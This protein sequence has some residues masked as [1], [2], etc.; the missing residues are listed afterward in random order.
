[1]TSRDVA[2][3]VMV[4]VICCSARAL[5]GAAPGTPD[6]ITIRMY[7]YARLKPGILVRTQ[8]EVGRIYRG[9]GVDIHWAE[10]IRET[11]LATTAALDV[12]PAELLVMLLNDRMA[13]RAGM[14]TDVVG[15]AATSEDGPGRIAYVMVDRARRAAGQSA[16]G[17]DDVLALVVAHELGH[18]L[19]P[20]GHL[21]LPH[22]SHSASGVM[23]ANLDLKDLPYDRGRFEFTPMQGETIRQ[24]VRTP[25]LAAEK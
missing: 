12:D 11:D 6:G 4:A 10:T 14:P 5:F 25:T 24:R 17:L 23:R 20:H 1:M 19:L 8:T 3:T 18:L 21:L 22:G 13:S 7:D 15:S 16:L 9:I 2:R